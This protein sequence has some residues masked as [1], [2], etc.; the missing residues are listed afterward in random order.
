MNLKYEID[1]NFFPFNLGCDFQTLNGGD[2]ANQCLK[3]SANEGI[4]SSC[5]VGCTIGNTPTNVEQAE[6][7]T[8]PSDPIPVRSNYVHWLNDVRKYVLGCQGAYYYSS[9]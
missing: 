5:Q 6:K 3:Y 2:C 4:Q 1:R 7:D 8:P 9:I